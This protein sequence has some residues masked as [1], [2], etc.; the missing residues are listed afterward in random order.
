MVGIYPTL[1][2]CSRSAS[3]STGALAHAQKPAKTRAFKMLEFNQRGW[4]PRN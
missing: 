1:K 3:L 4:M 2:A